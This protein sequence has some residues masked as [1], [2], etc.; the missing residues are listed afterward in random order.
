MNLKDFVKD[1]Y[2]KK[3]TLQLTDDISVDVN[4][5]PMPFYLFW[6]GL[7]ENG[8]ELTDDQL[9]AH[10]IAHCV[11]DDEGNPVFTYEQIIGK[12]PNLTLDPLL[13]LKLG[14]LLADNSK[15]GKM[16]KTSS[17]SKKNSGASLSSTELAEEQ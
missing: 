11:V 14:E 4:L 6:K 7:D 16:L 12:D 13:I 3:K 17:D 10:R 2:I 9:I 15:L 8:N 1:Q 5:R